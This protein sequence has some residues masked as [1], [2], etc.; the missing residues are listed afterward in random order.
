[1]KGLSVPNS[2]SVAPLGGLTISILLT[3]AMAAR[4]EVI[5]QG[6]PDYPLD[7]IVFTV[8][9]EGK[10]T[11]QRGITG[12]RNLRQTFQNPVTFDVGQIV[13]G[14]NVDDAGAA[15]A[16]LQIRI[17]EVADVLATWAPG[18]LVK[19]F[20]FP[21]LPADLGAS[22]TVRL[23]LT[24][25]GADIFTLPAR[26]TGNMGYGIEYSNNDG[27]N[28]VGLLR[29]TSAAATSQDYYA[30]GRYLVEGGGGNANRDTGLAL[31]EAPGSG[32]TPG[33]VDGNGLVEL[34][35]F[36]PIRANFRKQVLERGQ[37]DLNRDRVVNFADF[38]EWKTAFL[39]AGGALADVDFDVAANV[40][41]PTTLGLALL[42][43]LAGSHPLYYRRR[44][45]A[46]SSH[47]TT[48]DISTEY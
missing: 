28:V 39:G 41:E 16:G 24:L 43:S 40:P 47:A 5:L 37:G 10:D 2:T 3:A 45:T 36:D 22:S 33:D 6:D 23:G 25:T 26:N 11:N 4:A 30:A 7:A 8:D 21:T 46:R 31:A 14:I 1:M 32:P 44:P 13:M 42:A 29:H 12:T 17:Y 35:D 9:P 27:V 34:V 38:R 18:N 20:I 19:E 48:G 15:T